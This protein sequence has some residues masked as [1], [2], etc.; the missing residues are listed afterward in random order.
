MST[1]K[2]NIKISKGGK[3]EFKIKLTAYV[4]DKYKNAEEIPLAEAIKIAEERLEDYGSSN[5]GSEVLLNATPLF[6][7]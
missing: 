7:Y 1:P 3:I 2:K 6:E 5:D 4:P